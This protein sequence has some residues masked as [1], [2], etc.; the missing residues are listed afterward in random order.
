M[1]LTAVAAAL[2]G[3][4]LALTERSYLPTSGLILMV[5]GA[6]VALTGG[7]DASRYGVLHMRAFLGS[8]PERQETAEGVTALGMFLFV[9]LPLILIGSL[10]YGNG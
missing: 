1:L 7:H 4:C 8:G 5:L 9:S 3:V 6:V 10:L 2:A